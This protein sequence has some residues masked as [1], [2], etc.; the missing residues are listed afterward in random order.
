MRMLDIPY[1]PIDDSFE[2]DNEEESFNFNNPD[3]LRRL[4]SSTT[5]PS[6]YSSRQRNKSI[7]GIDDLEQIIKK[8]NK[9]HKSFSVIKQMEV[10]PAYR[11][12]VKASDSIRK[13][14][15]NVPKRNI[16]NLFV[17]QQENIGELNL[18]LAQK[19]SLYK[20]DL[21][22]FERITDTRMDSQL[23]SVEEKVLAEQQLPELL[24]TYQSLRDEL[25]QFDKK[26]NPVAFVKKL[27]EFRIARNNY[28]DARSSWE[29]SS[30][31]NNNLAR[32]INGLM[33]EEEALRKQLSRAMLL[34]ERTKLYQDELDDNA[35]HWISSTT[36]TEGVKYL[37]QGVSI[38][39]KYNKEMNQV[40]AES[41]KE[42]V[43]YA[44]NARFED[45]SDTSNLDM[46]NLELDKMSNQFAE[47][48]SGF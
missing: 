45:V 24:F 44:Q 35:Y 2:H 30:Y 27:R 22:Q 38:L 10:S 1:K 37:V 8:I 25:Q 15:T 17:E 7:E 33:K 40:F 21:E 19:I 18:K 36:I 28:L 43:S 4:Y 48:Y 13:N 16:Y 9:T 32:R 39:D 11:M 47:R 6:F 34:S 42:F 12:L 29:H 31:V 46:L 14:F 3:D 41:S 26:E 20:H 23:E 5:T